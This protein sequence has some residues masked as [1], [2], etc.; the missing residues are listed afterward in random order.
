MKK[1]PKQVIP[2][3]QENDLCCLVNQKDRLSSQE[4]IAYLK[5]LVQYADKIK[6]PVDDIQRIFNKILKWKQQFGDLDMQEKGVSRALRNS[7]KTAVKIH[8]VKTLTAKL[9]ELQGE[10]GLDDGELMLIIYTSVDHDYLTNL[11]VQAG[12]FLKWFNLN[13]EGESREEVD[14]LNSKHDIWEATV[15][16]SSE[17]IKKYE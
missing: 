14:F 10:I 8:N 16:L 12:E 3:V 4:I 11:I 2:K 17:V 6:D 13:F 1:K 15:H 5:Q 9:H 7:K